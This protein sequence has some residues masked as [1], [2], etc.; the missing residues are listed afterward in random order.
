MPEGDT[1]FRAART[2]ARAL[3][4]RTVTRFTT[5]LAAL[6]RVDDDAPLRGRT[7]ESVRA[8]GK[9]LLIDL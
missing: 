1:I 6:G 5:Q 8:V 7:I 3:G 4:G 2:L 9:N